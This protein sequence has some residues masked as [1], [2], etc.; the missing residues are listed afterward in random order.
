MRFTFVHAAGF[1]KDWKALRLTDEDLSAL[2][3][4]IAKQPDIGPVMKGT[5]GLRKMRFAPPSLHRGKS[6]SMRVGYV[7]FEDLETV[8]LVL[9]F[10][11]NAKD[12]LSAEEREYFRKLI[13]ALWQYTMQLEDKS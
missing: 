4:A 7:A 9:I 8:Y 6:G 10:P 13:P 5:S 2:E 11:K 1:S 3:S 12:N